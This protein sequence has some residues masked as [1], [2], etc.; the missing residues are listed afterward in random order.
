MNLIT[1]YPAY[2]FRVFVPSARFGVA[3][4][5]VEDRRAGNGMK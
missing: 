1:F 4:V 3:I 2:C 5:K